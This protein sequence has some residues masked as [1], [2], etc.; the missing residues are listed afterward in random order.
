MLDPEKLQDTKI[1]THG[2]R[3]LESGLLF[4]IAHKRE[5]KHQELGFVKEVYHIENFLGLILFRIQIL[6]C[7]KNFG[8]EF[9]H[10]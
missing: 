1:F 3:V 7:L 8:H 4:I 6:S 9:A 2:H 5:W 10:K